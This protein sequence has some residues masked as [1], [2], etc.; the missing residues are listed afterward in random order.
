VQRTSFKLAIVEEQAA[1]E[2]ATLPAMP[3]APEPIKTRDN[4]LRP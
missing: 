1:E 4:P 2:P 3:V